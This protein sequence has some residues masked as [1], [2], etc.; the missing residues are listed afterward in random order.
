MKEVSDNFGKKD[1]QVDE[2]MCR[3]LHDCIWKNRGVPYITQGIPILVDGIMEIYL[4]FKFI[5]LT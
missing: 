3:R 4:R 5:H 2:A 1:Q